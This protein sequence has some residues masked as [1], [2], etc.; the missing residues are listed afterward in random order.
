MQTMLEWLGSLGLERYAAVFAENDIDFEVLPS[1]TEQ[2]LVE[3]GVSM[4]HRKKILAAVRAGDGTAASSATPGAPEAMG[5]R[6]DAGE[7]RQLT[8]MFC[9][10]V[11]SMS[12]SERLDPEDLR[13]VIRAYQQCAAQV[14]ERF[15]GHI[16]QY[17]GDGLL[18]YFGHPFA[19]EDDAERSVRAAMGII[20]ELP[21]AAARTPLPGDLRL[22]VRVGI[23]TGLIVIGEVGGGARREV[24]AVGDTPNVAARLQALARADTIVISE[25]TQRLIAGSFDLEELGVQ[26]IRGVREPMRLWT[27]TGLASAERSSAAMA[28]ARSEF[29]GREDERSLIDERW[30]RA[31][32]GAGQVILLSGEAG[33]GKSRI[34]E[35][36]RQRVAGGAAAIQLQCSPYH[37]NDAFHPVIR[38]LARVLA[39]RGDE[40]DSI[41]FDRLRELVEVRLGRPP[42]DSALLASIL[43]IPTDA[44]LPAVTLPPLRLK[45][46]SIRALVDL[47]QAVAERA[48]A[49]V[50]VEDAHWADPTS[51]EVLSE[52]IARSAA[53][54]VLIIISHRPGFQAWADGDNVTTRTLSRLTQSESAALVTRVTGGKGLPKAL[55]A[56]IISKADGVPLFVEELT[57]LLLE[58]D[59]L[60]DSGGRY[61]YAVS[62]TQVVIPATLRDSLMAR[63]DRL[64]H[65]KQIAQIG[66]AIGREFSYELIAAVAKMPAHELDA[67]LAALTES[68]LALQRGGGAQAVY[69]FKHVLVQ[70]TAYDSMLKSRRQQLHQAIV[71]VLEDRYPALRETDPGLLARHT[72]AAGLIE[73][74]IPYWLQAA[75]LSL[76]RM[77][78]S[79][80]A[81]QLSRG[82]DLIEALPPSVQRD[83]RELPFHALLGTTYMLSKGWAA[84]EVEQAYNRAHELCASVENSQETIWPLWGVFVFRL[85]RGDI[86]RAREIAERI[87][88]LA[89]AASDRTAQ[90]VAHMVLVQANMYSGRFIEAQQ[91]VAGGTALYREADHRALISLYSTDL[92]LTL[93]VHQAHLLWLRGWPDRALE[94]CER[95]D[96]LARSL[97]HPYSISWALTWGAIPHLYRGDF[98]TLLERVAEGIRIAEEHGFVYTSSIGTMARGWAV[99]QLGDVEE[100]IELMRAGLDAFRTTGAGIVV[101]VF[102]TMQAELL[103]RAGRIAEGLALL[104][105][106]AAQVERW[107][108]RMHESEIHRTRGLLL[109]AAPNPD[110]ERA[111]TSL[112]HAVAVAAAQQATGWEL[113]A[114]LALAALLRTLGR[115]AEGLG[116]LA[117]VLASFQE[118]L[119]TADVRAATAFRNAVAD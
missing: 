62:E 19:H 32:A 72:S 53:L 101:P 78:L 68:G 95:N 14:I 106:A 118:G 6:A 18:V 7:R 114:A 34:L 115:D 110:Y 31:A 113:R 76:R 87:H 66:A 43:S 9:D 64:A 23:H 8:V 98:H 112:R 60:R 61:V 75:N 107:G 2:N 93:Q 1:L 100:G 45:Q 99:G 102:Q 63:L 46:E 105:A 48:P 94:L 42:Q 4:G 41:K 119:G 73:A 71:N 59:R 12:L 81:W 24:L 47:V 54:P 104:D 40:A 16:A 97:E 26:Q 36:A 37:I 69:T 44:R 20:A 89:A 80:A 22:A 91:H 77:A 35:E 28:A 79:E 50:L 57:K 86:T 55:M 117:P 15:D 39:L 84:A 5:D 25:H 67:A 109:A 38:E 29:V 74:A 116:V 49:L 13:A 58:S 21:S 27:V 52:L 103:G 10:L 11:D 108:E 82:L 111:E 88:S 83:R 51:L 3:L 56:Q 90:L 85:V 33:I 96:A 30:Q 70:E 17:L 92:L 65:V